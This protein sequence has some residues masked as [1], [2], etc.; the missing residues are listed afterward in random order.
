[1]NYNLKAILFSV[2]LVFV[3]TLLQ[4]QTSLA[5]WHTSCVPTGPNPGEHI[6]DFFA[7]HTSPFTTTQYLGYPKSPY[8]P[9]GR[10]EASELDKYDRILQKFNWDEPTFMKID[11]RVW[12]TKSVRSRYNLLKSKLTNLEYAM[13]LLVVRERKLE[14]ISFLSI[15]S[16]N[17]SDR[18]KLQGEFAA[19]VQHSANVSTT[20][21]QAGISPAAL[22][23]QNAVT[24]PGSTFQAVAAD[25]I[26][27]AW[28]SHYR[29]IS[30]K[31]DTSCNSNF[32]V[33]NGFRDPSK[34]QDALDWREYFLKVGHV[35]S[36]TGTP[37]ISSELSHWSAPLDGIHPYTT[38]I[39]I[40]TGGLDISHKPFFIRHVPFKENQPNKDN[41]SNIADD[42]ST[43]SKLADN[44][45]RLS[46]EIEKSGSMS[47]LRGLIESQFN[48][49]MD[50]VTALILDARE[51]T[52][53]LAPALLH[54]SESLKDTEV[55]RDIQKQTISGIK[56]R[57]SK[58]MADRQSKT[59][60]QNKMVK[61]INSAYLELAKLYQS[62][63][64]LLET[65][66]INNGTFQANLKDRRIRMNLRRELREAIRS[67]KLEIEELK[68]HLSTARM[69]LLDH[70]I[71]LETT[72]G[73]LRLASLKYNRV[74]ERLAILRVNLEAQQ[75]KKSDLEHMLK[76]LLSFQI[77]SVKFAQ[78]LP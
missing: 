33:R 61:L 28:S 22:Q 20:S 69:E 56:E 52:K 74:S 43:A 37:N 41:I 63:L 10:L 38:G 78:S 57:I 26:E 17:L 48:L 3:S 14:V 67:Q 62:E 40:N 66:P 55:Q 60:D 24:N 59:V 36:D 19:R 1:M 49:L 73:T 72:Y 75:A 64:K 5:N 51:E 27:S 7:R 2:P 9:I 46:S 53:S 42:I 68:Q 25:P 6:F 54:L 47:K 35:F 34:F 8:R 21:H 30:P 71:D 31:F 44:I 15:A 23:L 29:A 32:E 11:G 45:A 12:T 18:L 16:R 65:I 58:I 13:E 39:N 50:P 77:L 4:A 70:T 76:R